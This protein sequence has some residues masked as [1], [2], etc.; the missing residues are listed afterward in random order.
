MPTSYLPEIETRPLKEIKRFQEKKLKELLLY[1][2]E[3]SPY[4][5]RLFENNKVTV[6]PNL[7]NKPVMLCNI[8]FT[9]L[10]CA[11][12]IRIPLL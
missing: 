12:N 6:Y 1:L 3:H 2:D 5:H 11:D 4:Y 10:V 7:Y 9:L 8:Y